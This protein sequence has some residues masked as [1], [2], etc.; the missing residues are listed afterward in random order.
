MLAT[1]V[2]DR[3]IEENDLLVPALT[4]NDDAEVNA[5]FAQAVL[6]MDTNELCSAFGA[7][8]ALPDEYE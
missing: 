8:G 4:A 3:F 7:V 2:Y 5:L 1:G 6:L